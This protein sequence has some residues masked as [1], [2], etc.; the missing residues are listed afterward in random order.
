MTCNVRLLTKNNSEINAK[1]VQQNFKFD[2]QLFKSSQY[3]LESNDDQKTDSNADVSDQ[4]AADDDN[5]HSAA[6]QK[7]EVYV[8][9]TRRLEV[10][11]ICI[12]ISFPL[13][14]IYILYICTI[15]KIA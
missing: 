9:R 13:D 15:R 10:N 6:N 12:S 1:A 5:A 4:A 7:E 8:V 14:Y 3:K 2:V 11:L